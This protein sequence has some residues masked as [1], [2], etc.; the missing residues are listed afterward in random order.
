MNGEENK[1]HR[2]LVFGPFQKKSIE[3][4][5]D[6]LAGLADEMLREWKIGQVRNVFR[7]MTQYMLRVTSS[8]LFGFDV[9]ELAYNIGAMIERWAGMNHHLVMR[10]FFSDQPIT[11]T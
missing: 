2:R 6:A 10:P 1:R 8:V 4:Y 11:A 9:P 3:T 5:R 7:D